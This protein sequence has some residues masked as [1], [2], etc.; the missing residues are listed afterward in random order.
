MHLTASITIFC[1]LLFPPAIHAISSDV[2]Q[3][4]CSDLLYLR[5]YA[6]ASSWSQN[7]AR[8]RQ[9]EE[10]LVLGHPAYRRL[11]LETLAEYE[12]PETSSVEADLAKVRLH[13][14]NVLTN[15]ADDLKELV[16]VVIL[17]FYNRA[18]WSD[19]RSAD[20]LRGLKYLDRQKA[21]AA[22]RHIFEYEP[23][24]PRVRIDAIERR[25][26]NLWT[27]RGEVEISDQLSLDIGGRTLHLVAD[28][29]E[30]IMGLRW[31]VIRG[32][33]LEDGT[34]EIDL[35]DPSVADITRGI[36]T[37]GSFAVNIRSEDLFAS[38]PG[39]EISGSVGRF[40]V[41]RVKLGSYL[42]RRDLRHSRF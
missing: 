30:D 26:R 4:W 34:Q 5:K 17:R 36:V 8:T 14:V 42:S 40:P 25:G 11:A 33:A 20:D 7:L 10:L 29:D 22:F 28:H 27:V 41:E 24:R 6:D 32:N 2:N 21:I 19:L 31:L 23:W 37:R 18:Q 38:D 9:A 16:A 35:Q 15:S 12:L 1:A 13:L 39:V 3:A